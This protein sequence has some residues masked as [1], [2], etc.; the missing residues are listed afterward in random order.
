LG[1]GLVDMLTIKQID[2]ETGD[3]LPAFGVAGATVEDAVEQYKN[4]KGPGVE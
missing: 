1:I 3:E 4:V 2:P